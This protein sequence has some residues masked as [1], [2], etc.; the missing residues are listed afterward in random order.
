[1]SFIQALALYQLKVATLE[2][3]AE[4]VRQI[5][6][7]LNEVETEFNNARLEEKTTRRALM[8]AARGEETCARVSEVIRPSAKPH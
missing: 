8:E 2:E 1:M 4:E 7:R 6:L 3:L 5:R